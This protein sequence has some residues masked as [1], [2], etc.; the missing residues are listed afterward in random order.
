VVDA[1]VFWLVY[2][3]NGHPQFAM[4]LRTRVTRLHTTTWLEY[5]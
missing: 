5:L 2:K 4:L 1:P 3:S